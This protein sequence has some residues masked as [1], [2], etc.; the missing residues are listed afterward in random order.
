MPSVP[1]HGRALSARRGGESTNRRVGGGGRQ[2]SRGAAWLHDLSAVIPISE[3]TEEATDLS[4]EVLP[5]EVRRPLLFHQ[6]L[7]EVIA[8]K[9]FG[10]ADDGMLSAAGCH[11]TLR[12]GVVVP[13]NVLFVA[14]TV[15]WDGRGVSPSRAEMPRA[16]VLVGCGGVCLPACTHALWEG[17]QALSV[18]HP[19]LAAAHR[20]LCSCPACRSVSP[21]A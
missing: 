19:C 5:D 1:A 2:S 14:D 10:A 15:K 20:D 7:S 4:L 8:W 6:K 11:P 12:P 18:I 9:V 16:C 21:F 13:D 3:R 17:R